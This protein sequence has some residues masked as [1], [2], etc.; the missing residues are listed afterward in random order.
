MTSNSNE[1]NYA[2]ILYEA[3]QINNNVLYEDLRTVI[4][5]FI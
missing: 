5:S 3:K 2:D 4:T 1:D